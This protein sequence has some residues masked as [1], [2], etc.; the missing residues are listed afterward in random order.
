MTELELCRWC[1]NAT[2]HEGDATDLAKPPEPAL[3]GLPICI[4]NIE[5]TNMYAVVDIQNRGGAD[6]LGTIIQISQRRFT[7]ETVARIATQHASGQNPGVFIS[8]IGVRLKPR[9]TQSTILPGSAIHPC[10][11]DDLWG[12][13]LAISQIAHRPCRELVALGLLPFAED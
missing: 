3:V 13:P 11:I 10:Q 6:S 4:T 8:C 5:D 9:L 1:D 2:R 7:N 12:K